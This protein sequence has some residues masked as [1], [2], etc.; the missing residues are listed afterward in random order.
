MF[1]P[2]NQGS[3]GPGG[4]GGQGNPA[5]PA[6]HR[7]AYLWEQVWARDTWLDLQHRFAQETRSGTERIA[8]FPRYHQWH[9]VTSLVAHAARHGAGHH[10]LLQHS[11]GSGK[12]NSIAWLA[13]RLADLHTAT[14]AVDG[15]A[16]DELVFDKVVVITDRRVLDRQLQDTISGLEHVLGLLKRI[17]TDSQQLREALLDTK[18]KIIITTLQKFPVIAADAT[19]AGKRVA[20]IVDE[21]HSSQTGDAAKGLKKV[22]GGADA[23]AAAEADA[24]SSEPPDAQDQLVEV[25]TASTRA[26]GRHPNLSFFAFTATPKGKTLQLFGTPRDEAGTTVY[27]PFTCIRCARPSRRASSSTCWPTTSATAATTA[28]PTG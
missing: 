16:P 10:Y 20:V 1:L 28:S 17:D 5:N 24:A 23:L 22:L 3:A 9:A 12:S 27:E 4:N 25:I 19:V 8:L 13:H 14:D 6:G 21:A 15:V 2:F 26:R 11:A 7:T 18:T